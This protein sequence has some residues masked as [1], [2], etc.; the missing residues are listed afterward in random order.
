MNII[1]PK[2]IKKG[3]TIAI[4]A[5]SWGGHNPYP[6]IVNKG[7]ERLE[8]FGFKIKRGD[9]LNYTNQELYENPKLRADDLHKQLLDEEVRGIITL[10]GGYESVRV[11]PFLDREIIKNNPKFFMGYSDI[12]TYLTFFSNLGLV[13]FNGPAVMAGF[14]ESKNLEKD[15]EMYIKEFLLGNWDEFEYKKFNRYTNCYLSWDD[16]KNLEKEN[17]NYIENND[18][19]HFI[20][21]SKVAE[22]E[23]FGGCIEV[24]EFMKG[25]KFWPDENFWNN[26][27]LFF[28]T[29]EEKPPII[30]V[31]SFLRNYGMQ[32]ILN[33]INGIC[34]GRARD[35]SEEEKK[36]LETVI[37]K[38]LK[39]FNRGDLVVVTNMDFGHTDPQ[40]VM[41]NGIKAQINPKEKTFKLLESIWVD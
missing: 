9:T 36:E 25:T 33:K 29:S 27:L 31:E 26:K 20:Q 35:Y 19:W 39:E 41:P 15:F 37:L 11:L 10:I 30:C 17:L 13:S 12:S 5:L 2:K 22:G 18:D 6:H 24:L 34:F 7:V 28:E 1:K 8:S 4:V 40:L 14:A 16:S 23:L 21:G 3:D 32:G 38:V